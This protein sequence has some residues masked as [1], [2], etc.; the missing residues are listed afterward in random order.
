MQIEE[1]YI[2]K[3]YILNTRVQ[4][5][6]SYDQ[7]NPQDQELI[8]LA[9]KQTKRAYAPYSKFYVGAALRLNNDE[10]FVGCNQENASYPLCMCGERVALY[11][12][13]SSFPNIPVKTIAI[14]A[15]NPANPVRKPVTPCGACRQVLTEFEGR[16][17]Q[18]IRILLKGDT[19]EVMIFQ[20]GKA[21]LPF[22]F[23]S[24]YL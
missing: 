18:D 17:A 1:G 15:H 10:I 8:N 24:S 14:I 16:F 2:H 9:I 19:D 21:L 3:I 20:S 4:H 23:D 6:T 7:L 12:A 11:N 5:S 22:S 13:A